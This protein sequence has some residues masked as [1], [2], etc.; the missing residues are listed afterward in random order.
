MNGLVLISGAIC[1]SHGD[2]VYYELTEYLSLAP[3]L[4]DMVEVVLSA[5]SRMAQ[6]VFRT[7]SCGKLAPKLYTAF[8]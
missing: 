7:N 5:E 4:G 6:I 1:F 8:T 3:V 2:V